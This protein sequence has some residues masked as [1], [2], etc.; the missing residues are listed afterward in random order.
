[1]SE[2]CLTLSE[3]C[4]FSECNIVGKEDMEIHSKEDSW[5]PG[6]KSTHLDAAL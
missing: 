2:M 3:S 4:D 6:E 5:Q 1:M